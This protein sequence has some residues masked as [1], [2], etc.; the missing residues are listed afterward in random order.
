MN[1][2]FI[3]LNIP[4]EIKD[5]I[6]EIRNSVQQSK[7]FKWE[8][9]EKLHLTLKFIGEVDRSILNPII[10]ELNFIENYSVINCC[11]FKFDFF[12]RNK[13]PS[14]LWAGLKTDE[15]LLQ[16]VDDLNDRLKKL[17]I[18]IEEKKFKS[19]LTLLRLKNDPGINF[20]NSFKNFTF[21]PIIFTA[22]SVSVIKS[23]LN[24][25]GSKYFELKNYKL[26]QL[27]K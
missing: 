3:A 16:L 23:E 18:P 19:H 14:I 25:S 21:E 11:I 17:S 9:K 20:V 6:I 13:K 15:T 7:N 22:N 10:D 12:F 27:E 24:P 5:N 26:K 8:P 4:E 2:L 1:R